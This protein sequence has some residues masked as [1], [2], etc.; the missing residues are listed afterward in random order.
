MTTNLSPEIRQLPLFLDGVPHGTDIGLAFAPAA[1]TAERVRQG[2]VQ[3]AHPDLR[4]PAA[5][6]AAYA[7]RGNCPRWGRLAVHRHFDIR[8]PLAAPPPVRAGG[9]PWTGS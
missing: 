3:A 4:S 8:A 9:G 6:K 7:D 5:V 2:H 1:L